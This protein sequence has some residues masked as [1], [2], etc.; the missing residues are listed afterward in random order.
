MKGFHR[1]GRVD[2]FREGRGKAVLVEGVKVGVFKQH[3]RI[4]ALLD[5]CPHMGASLADGKLVEGRVTCHWHGWTFDLCTGRTD[6][7]SWACAKVYEVHIDGGEVWVK[8][9]A[10]P[11]AV[12]QEEEEWVVWDDTKHLKKQDS[13]EAPD[14]EH[15]AHQADDEADED[16]EPGELER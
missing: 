4:H 10:P 6:E 3:G 14:G 9:P 11:P 1:V 2:E 12:E 8:P 15:G 7:S 5:A 16:N 13:G